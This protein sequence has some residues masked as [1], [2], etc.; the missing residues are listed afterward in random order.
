MGGKLGGVS[1]E[2]LQEKNYSGGYGTIEHTKEFFYGI[3]L[4]TNG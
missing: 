2:D 4:N 3:R 1:R